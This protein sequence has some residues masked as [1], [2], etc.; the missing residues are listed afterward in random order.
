MH[1]NACLLPALTRTYTSC[2]LLYSTWFPLFVTSIPWIF[3]DASSAWIGKDFADLFAFSI[4]MRLYFYASTK[5]KKGLM[6]LSLASLLIS[7]YSMAWATEGHD[8]GSRR[9][10]IVPGVRVGF[11]SLL[12]YS[13]HLGGDEGVRP[14]HF[15]WKLFSHLA[16]IAIRFCF[17]SGLRFSRRRMRKRGVSIIFYSSS[18]PVLLGGIIP[19]HLLWYVLDTMNPCQFPWRTNPFN[20][21]INRGLIYVPPFGYCPPAQM[22]RH[23]GNSATIKIFCRI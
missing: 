21:L 23:L 11:I 14:M 15:A 1:T 19:I 9:P 18:Y 4:A 3:L 6:W 16:C 22:L 5:K 12:P 20:P 17:R 2:Y 13:S 8:I 7:L 10:H